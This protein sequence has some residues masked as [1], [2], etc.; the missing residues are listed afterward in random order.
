MFFFYL[1][2]QRRGATIL[3]DKFWIVRLAWAT[4]QSVWMVSLGNFISRLANFSRNTELGWSERDTSLFA[5]AMG[6]RELS[7]M[8]VHR[9]KLISECVGGYFSSVPDSKITHFLLTKNV[10]KGF[11]Q[12]K[13]SENPIGSRS[14]KKHSPAC[15]HQ[16]SRTKRCRKGLQRLRSI[17]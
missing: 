4:C 7:Y 15:I 16:K 12:I 13:L 8:S 11:R 6:R 5:S 9:C 1:V 2:F 10:P 17:S 14:W 3:F